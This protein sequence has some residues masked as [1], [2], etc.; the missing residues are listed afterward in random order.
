MNGDKFVLN[1][2]YL[3]QYLVNF[4]KRYE[5]LVF[6][7]QESNLLHNSVEWGNWVYDCLKRNDIN[8]MIAALN[9]VSK[10]YQPGKLASN[11]LRSGK[12]LMICLITDITNRAARDR[13]VSNELILTAADICI[14]MCEETATYEELLRCT[15]AG[16]I[17]ISNLIREYKEREY[18]PLIKP[19]KEY[20]Y[21][22]LHGHIKLA[23]IAAHLGVTPEHLSRTFHA[24]EGITLK[25]YIIEERIN[26]AKNLLR[27]SDYSVTDIASYLAFSS[28]SHFTEVFKSATG[29]TPTVYR[30]DF[31]EYA[32]ITD[33]D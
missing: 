7:R 3:N 13:L 6:E 26:R 5:K 22:H 27:F 11:E 1:E 19:T 2:K 16:L 25:Q 15:C 24:A 4:E 33:I 30:R 18:H 20:I 8:S 12:N 32:Y 28:A 23:D 21:K 29:K 9:A 17:K 10:H 31:V 14:L